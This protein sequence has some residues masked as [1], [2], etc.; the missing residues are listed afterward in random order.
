MLYATEAMWIV[1]D[2]GSLGQKS[3]DAL[4]T[5]VVFALKYH[6]KKKSEGIVIND[7]G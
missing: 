2:A 4:I 6:Y 1:C 3:S 5:A 7:Y